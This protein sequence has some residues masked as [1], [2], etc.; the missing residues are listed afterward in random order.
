M[1]RFLFP[2]PLLLIA[3]LGFGATLASNGTV[4][5]VQAKHD[6]ATAGDTITMPGGSFP[7]SSGLTITKAVT[8]E[9]GAGGGTTTI[10][11]NVTGSPL[12]T[13]TMTA[14]PGT[15]LTRLT[16]FDIVAGSSTGHGSNTGMIRLNGSNTN[17]W[18]IRIDHMTITA[19]KGNAIYAQTALGVVDHV[20]F[21]RHNESIYGTANTWNG[22]QT[23][24]GGWAHPTNAGSLDNGLTYEDCVFDDTGGT[25]DKTWFD[26]NRGL[27]LVVRHSTFIQPPGHNAALITCHGIEARN[28]SVRHLEAYDNLVVTDGTSVPVNNRGGTGILFNWRILSAPNFVVRFLLTNDRRAEPGYWGRAS[29]KNPWD[30]N[31]PN[32]GTSNDPIE[33]YSGTCAAGTT[34]THIVVSPSPAW[35]TNEW[36]GYAVTNT[37]VPDNVVATHALNA[38]LSVGSAVLSN[39]ANSLTL[40]SAI[41]K[42]EFL[43]FNPGDNF[44]IYRV[45]NSH[46]QTGRAGGL[47][48][49]R[50]TGNP[51]AMADDGTARNAQ[52]SEPWH[53][54][55]NRRVE[56]N[57]TL[58]PI[59]FAGSVTYTR[60]CT[61]S[62]DDECHYWNDDE[63]MEG[64][65]WDADADAVIGAQGMGLTGDSAP[66]TIPGYGDTTITYPHPLAGG[67]PTSK[68]IFLSGNLD[69]GNVII[70]DTPTAVLGVTNNGDSTLTVSSVGYDSVFTGA[71]AGFSVAPSATH[72]VTVTATPLL[73]QDYDG[74]I[75]VN[76]DA[77]SGL[78]TIPAHVKGVTGSNQ[79]PGDVFW[80]MK[81]LISKWLP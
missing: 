49:D 72:N 61:G 15:G 62:N 3:S 60:E 17:L 71:T 4:A 75:T 44:K 37:S 23:G 77:D 50:I 65:P 63:P 35:D 12:I 38:D 43:V 1:R 39:D 24:D 22:F 31:D 40:Y 76:S 56:D 79:R 14:A 55:N 32:G 48:A 34:S 58:T 73:A 59:L 36:L 2:L 69:Y 78:E 57:D 30:D 29:G 27:R 70:G 52:E 8:I 16:D 5:D 81:N 26:G 13:V 28:R 74:T 19:T 11:D 6:S 54:W 51:A 9:G 67:V 18:R 41:F 25:A 53:G 66:L 68:I 20:R 80:H 47:A 42:P 46:D 64:Y 45:K 7:W 33:F 10:T 21:D